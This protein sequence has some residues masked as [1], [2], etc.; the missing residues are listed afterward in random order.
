MSPAAK[1][2]PATP[3]ND[4]P[5]C[6]DDMIG[7]PS[8]RSTLTPWVFIETSIV[9]LEAPST[10][11]RAPTSSGGGASTMRLTASASAMPPIQRHALRADAT[12]A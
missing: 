11:A 8:S 10:K 4:Q 2:A 6:S 7:R 5:A 3:P 9:A 12:T 1:P